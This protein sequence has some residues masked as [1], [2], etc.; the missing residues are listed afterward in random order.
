ME[1]L[2]VGHQLDKD[3][4][5]TMIIAINMVDKN[6]TEGTIKMEEISNIEAKVHM[7]KTTKTGMLNFENP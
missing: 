6:S 5:E 4:M 1:D 7:E 3:N 2:Q